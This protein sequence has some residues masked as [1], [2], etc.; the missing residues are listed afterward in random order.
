MPHSGTTRSPTGVIAMNQALHRRRC[1]SSGTISPLRRRPGITAQE[2]STKATHMQP[3]ANAFLVEGSSIKVA[4][5]VLL[6]QLSDPG[7]PPQPQPAVLRRT[8]DGHLGALAGGH[9]LAPRL[10]QVLAPEQP[11]L[12]VRGVEAPPLLDGRQGLPRL[13]EV[14]HATKS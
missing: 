12:H 2:T 5:L 1:G 6:R 4:C 3:A 7:A 13:A 10:P 11:R 8:A 9:E 14:E